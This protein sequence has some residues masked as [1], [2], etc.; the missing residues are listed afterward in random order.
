MAA[1][2]DVTQV[3]GDPRVPVH[4]GNKS[5]GEKVR[6]KKRSDRKMET[7]GRKEGGSR[8]AAAQEVMQ[9]QKQFVSALGQ[10]GRER[11]GSQV[12]L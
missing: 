2:L 3:I 6:Q 7:Q 5:E 9:L 8:K 4:F 11:E 12:A 1:K 10:A